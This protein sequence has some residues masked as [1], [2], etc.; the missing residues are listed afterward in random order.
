MALGVSIC[1]T[2][3]YLGVLQ[4]YSRPSVPSGLVIFAE[5]VRFELTVPCET[6]VFKTGAIDHS[7]TPPCGHHTD[8][9]GRGNLYTAAMRLMGI[10]FG[11]KNIGVAL[12]DE[13]AV[14]AFPKDVVRNGAD[15]LEK[16]ASIAREAEVGRIVIGESRDFTGGHNPVHAVALVFA[17]KLTALT[18]LP[19]SWEP[20]FL[21]SAEAE[22]IQG[23]NGSLDASAAALILNSFIAKQHGND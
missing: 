11:T 16:I 9:R 8:C 22:R 13:A 21:T 7:A 19:V 18:G 10:D 1:G 15:A 17:D 6:P 4:K 3:D 5:E 20:E 2:S 14:M 23:R 12:S